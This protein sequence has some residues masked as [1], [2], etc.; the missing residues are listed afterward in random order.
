MISILAHFFLFFSATVGTTVGREVGSFLIETEEG[1][2]LPVV[3]GFY[4]FISIYL[5]IY[6]SH[7]VL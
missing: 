1:D 6:L 5:S 2:Q 7:V 4:I 3:I